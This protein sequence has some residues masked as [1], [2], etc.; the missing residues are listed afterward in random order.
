MF[1]V[2]SLT[3]LSFRKVGVGFDDDELRS[4]A[5]PIGYAPYAVSLA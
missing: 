1:L 4:R 5:I 2:P 3:T